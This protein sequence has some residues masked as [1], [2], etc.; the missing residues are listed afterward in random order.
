MLEMLTVVSW[1]DSSFDMPS[2][3][4]FYAGQSSWHAIN[5]IVDLFLWYLVPDALG[6]Q[7]QAVNVC[8]TLWEHSNALFDKGPAIF[9]GFDLGEDGG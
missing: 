1:L 4:L 5:H 2:L 6:H 9:D 7:E 3:C 8:G